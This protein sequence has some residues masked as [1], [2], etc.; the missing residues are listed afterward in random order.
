MSVRLVLSSCVA[1][2]LSFSL[3]RCSLFVFRKIIKLCFDAIQGHVQS[4][5]DI[6]NAQKGLTTDS[7]IYA[8][9]N[10]FNEKENDFRCFKTKSKW[11]NVKQEKMKKKIKRILV[12]RRDATTWHEIYVQTRTVH[13]RYAT[14]F[15]NSTI[16]SLCV[17]NSFSYT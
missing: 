5:F 10:M 14:H 1:L 2:P 15:I 13:F 6:L 8:Y 12:S 16:N 9:A 3:Y 17:F 7:R 11:M 4:R